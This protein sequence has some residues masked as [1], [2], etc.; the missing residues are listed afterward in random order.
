[1]IGEYGDAKAEIKLVSSF[2]GVTFTIAALTYSHEASDPVT[3]VDYN[4]VKFYNMATNAN[5]GVTDS[6]T[7]T[8]DI[9]CTKLYTEYDYISPAS[10]YFC[11]AYYNS[12]NERIS[13]FSEIVL[14]TTFTRRSVRRV[15]ESALRKAMTKMD[16]TI[17][18]ELNWTNALDIVQDGID[19]I[20]ARKRKWPFL[21]KTDATTTDTVANTAYVAKPSDISLLEYIVVNNVKLELYSQN[22]YLVRTKAGASVITGTPSHYTEMNN[23]YYFYPTPAGAYDVEFNYFKVP[24]TI[25]DLSTEI[26]LVFVPILIYYCASQFSYIRGNDKRGD[27]M[28]TMF[29]KIL[30]QQCIEFSGPESGDAEYVEMTSEIIYENGVDL[31]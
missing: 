11:T 27:K 5:P 21:R 4:Q 17:N 28:Y 1:M 22:D 9:D 26:D 31:L 29:E 7:A 15:I 14:S 8:L 2:S 13:D 18:G 6:A 25:T 3:L 16:D 24:A 12:T 20:L 30:E 10:S 23:K 19:E